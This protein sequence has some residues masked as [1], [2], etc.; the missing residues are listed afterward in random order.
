MYGFYR[1]RRNKLLTGVL[2]GL[3]DKFQWDI[4][5]VRGIFLA[6]TIFTKVGLLAVAL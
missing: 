6:I 3:A 1:L 2:A 4:W 5:L